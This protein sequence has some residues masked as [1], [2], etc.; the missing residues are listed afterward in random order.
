MMRLKMIS[1]FFYPYQTSTQKILTE[2]AE[3][4][5]ENGL[6]VSVL[7]TKNAYREKKQNLKKHEVYKGIKIKRVA[8]SSLNR[9]S[10]IGRIVNYWT[11]TVGVL[12]NLLFNND[13]DKLLFVSNPPLV[14]FIG[15][16]VK[17]I[18]GKSYIY[19]VHDV[20]PDVAI[21]LGV[22]KPTSIIAKMMNF[23]NLKIYQNA[24][25]IV[26]LG[27]DMQRVIEKK[28]ISSE[29]IVIIT[30]WADS[31]KNH[32]KEVSQEFYE[33][34]NLKNKFNVMYTG[35]I[36][37][38]H[39]I[40][41]VLE[42]ARELKEHTD[43]QFMIIG[44]GNRKTYIEDVKKREQLHN[45]QLGNY[46]YGD[47]Y[48]NLLNCSN[49]FITTLQD[50]LEGLGVPSKTYTYMSVYKPLLGIMSETSEI[51]TMINKYNLG[52]QYASG[53]EKN[54]A[55]FILNIKN[56]PQNYQEYC[57]NVAKTFN[58]YYER[59]KVTKKFY[60]EIVG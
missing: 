8:A 12:F 31:T 13:Y 46:M 1:E 7:T 29:K 32:P 48:N 56:E 36:S 44:D 18:K 37:K 11:F 9:D 49:L 5:V 17:K 34:H 23:M 10:F 60:E 3:D 24:E 2:L 47:E 20:Y 35:N 6:E 45:I 19:L 16:L 55:E 39:A 38:V 42:I 21:K 40:D 52:A 4:L 27:L 53:L 14:P 30:N 59:K 28:G 22:I 26:V 57:N 54:M 58:T 43:I 41:S 33:K 51:G 25:K 50:G 15:Y